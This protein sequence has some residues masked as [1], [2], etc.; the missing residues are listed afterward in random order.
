GV[1]HGGA[2]VRGVLRRKSP[3]K[4]VATIATRPGSTGGR[5]TP[6]RA[7]SPLPLRGEELCARGDHPTSRAHRY[8]EEALSPGRRTPHRS[9]V[10]ATLPRAQRP[11]CCASLGISRYPRARPDRGV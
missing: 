9:E 4:S 1:W 7:A 10:A 5:A 6:D 8:C 2:T 3:A 11:E